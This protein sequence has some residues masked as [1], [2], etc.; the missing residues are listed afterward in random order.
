MHE[1]MQGRFRNRGMGSSEANQ[2]PNAAVRARDGP[3]AYRGSIFSARTRLQLMCCAT[4]CLLSSNFGRET[5]QRF[6][7]SDSEF[8]GQSMSISD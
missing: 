3:R 1:C 2:I 7:G 5:E 6:G 8:E 4:R